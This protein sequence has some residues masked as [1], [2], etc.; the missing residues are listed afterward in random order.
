MKAIA[1]THYGPP[2][3]LHLK[4]VEKPIPK[5]NEILVKI[6]ATAV[7]SGD[8]RLRKADFW[9]DETQNKYTRQRFFR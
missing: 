8:I 7:N 2:D 3:V 5:D 4:E 1:Y 9:I 6:I